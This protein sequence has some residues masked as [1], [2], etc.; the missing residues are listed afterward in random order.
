MA[1][2]VAITLPD[3]PRHGR[4]TSWS[5]KRH[6]ALAFPPYSCASAAAEAPGWRLRSTSFY[7]NASPCQRRVFL[8]LISLLFFVHDPAKCTHPSVCTLT[9]SCSNAPCRAMRPRGRA[10]GSTT[11]R[12]DPQSPRGD[13]REALSKLPSRGCLADVGFARRNTFLGIQAHMPWP[14]PVR[15]TTGV[16]STS[17]S[18]EN[19]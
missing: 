15:M 4:E 5:R 16:T 8:S 17:T 10:Y 1:H 11:S 6:E 3:R 14:P 2:G 9:L 7:L 18:R 19:S 13:R 12:H